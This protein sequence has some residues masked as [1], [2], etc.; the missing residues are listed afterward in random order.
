MAVARFDGEGISCH[1]IKKERAAK[2][3]EVP[4]TARFIR[5]K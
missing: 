5:K 1:L 3:F 4:S 2:G